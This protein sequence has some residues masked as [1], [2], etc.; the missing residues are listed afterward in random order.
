M[1]FPIDVKKTVYSPGSAQTD[2]KFCEAIAGLA[3]MAYWEGKNGEKCSFSDEQAEL[4]ELAKAT[5]K[6]PT[7]TDRRYIRALLKMCNEAYQQG[8]ADR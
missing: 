5:G 1:R 6:S 7:E 3:N 4:A 2:R 8:Q